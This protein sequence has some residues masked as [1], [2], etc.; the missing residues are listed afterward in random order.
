MTPVDPRQ[1]VAE[2]GSRD[3]HRAVSRRWP[4]EPPTLQPLREQAR[5]LPIVPDDLQEI[6]PPTAE[7]EQVTAQRIMPEH[8]LDLQRQARKAPPHI[9]MPGGQPNSD[10]CRDRDHRSPSASRTRASAAEST[11]ASTMTRQPCAST[12]SIRPLLAPGDS[13]REGGVDAAGGSG[14]TIAGTKVPGAAASRSS[15]SFRRQVKSCARETPCRRAVAEISRGPARLS[16]TI[17]TFS[18]SDQ[19]R[20]R[21]VSTIS[22]RPKALCI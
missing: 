16:R 9:R 22:S 5:A 15:L 12:I 7:A 11:S 8:F 13:T 17:R 20:R 21:P 4:Q 18:S 10:A 1:Q 14:A 6:A 3:R 2:L 19:R